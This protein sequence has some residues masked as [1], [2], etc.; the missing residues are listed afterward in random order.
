MRIIS[1]PFLVSVRVDETSVSVRSIPTLFPS[2]IIVFSFPINGV[3][4]PP[5]IWFFYPF[6][7]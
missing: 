3:F 2:A 1:I 6:T 4:S 7:L 5:I